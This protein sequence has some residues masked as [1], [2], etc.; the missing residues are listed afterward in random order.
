MV[1][2]VVWEILF[3]VVV[4]VVVVVGVSGWFDSKDDCCISRIEPKSMVT[5]LSVLLSS[6][7][8][9]ILSL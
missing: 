8:V 5:G 7:N 6:Y 4:L 1:V 3:E 9:V 2:A